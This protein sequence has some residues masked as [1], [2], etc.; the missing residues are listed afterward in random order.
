[1]TN[2]LATL[3]S[4]AIYLAF[5][6]WLGWRR[7]VRRELIVF[8][9]ALIMW[10]LL[11]ERGDLFVNITNLIVGLVNTARGQTTTTEFVTAEAREPFLFVVWVLFLV[12][13]YVLTF[14]RIDDK[15]S[16]R[17]GWAIILGMVNAL[18]F[19]VAFFPSLWAMLSP[20]DTLPDAVSET[21]VLT[22]LGG[23]LELIWDG[24][25]SLWDLIAPM[26]S[27][28]MLVMLTLI[29]VLAATSI[30]GSRAKS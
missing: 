28:A 13:A 24:I 4:F 22:L 20:D 10:I 30:R 7:G 2:E 26:G 16:S 3:V 25:A 14:T 9:V 5:F 18:F 23:G 15:D 29:L 11:Q 19:A 12:A 6:G 21:G 8:F 1:M 27:L 17:N